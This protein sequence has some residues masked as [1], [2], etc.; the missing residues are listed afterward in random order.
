VL[1]AQDRPLVERHVRQPDGSWA[2]TEICDMM[3]TFSFA[4]I[5]VAIPLVEIYRDVEF[6]EPPPS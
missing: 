5:P 4:S 2:K 1:I 6:P 3:Q